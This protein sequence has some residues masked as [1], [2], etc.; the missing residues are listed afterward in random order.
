VPR[1][2]YQVHLPCW[3]AELSRLAGSPAAL[4]Q[5]PDA[6]LDRLAELGFDLLWA[7]GVWETGPRARAKA[8]ERWRSGTDGECGWAEADVVASPFAIAEYRLSKAVGSPESFKRFRDR[9]RQRGL[10]LMVDFVPNHAGL[11]SPLLAAQPD[12]FVQ[13]RG[14]KDGFF[15]IS[16]SSGPIHIAHGKDPY[17]PAWE[18]TAQFE[19][20]NPDVW[21]LHRES[22]A[23]IARMADA[24]R[25]DMAMLCLRDVF[26][27]TWAARPHPGG[28]HAPD[29]P[30]QSIFEPEDELLGTRPAAVAEAYWDMEPRVLGA[31]LDFCYLKRVYD[32]LIQR[33]HSGL[34]QYLR[35]NEQMLPRGV[36]FLENHDEARI[37]S[38]LTPEEHRLAALLIHTLPGA[39]L[40]HWGQIEGRRKFTPCVFTRRPE[41]EVQ[42]EIASYYG[43]LL[44]FVKGLDG[45]CGNAQFHLPEARCLDGVAGPPSHPHALFLWNPE[46]GV[47]GV[48]V[49]LVLIHFGLEETEVVVE[50]PPTL[51]ASGRRRMESVFSANPG[52]RIDVSA[53]PGGRIRARLGRMSGEVFRI[54]VEA[55]PP[56]VSDVGVLLKQ[57]AP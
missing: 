36:F 50:L 28:P 32:F 6:E 37:A 5:V 15:Q 51:Q 13:S 24:V 22:L 41:E 48:S 55:G 7:M 40:T 12:C 54:L 38:L 30:L 56:K 45:E 43:A 16:G 14:P 46:S 25:V 10:G 17:F 27:R 8:L 11:D 52:S 34:A 33:N 2:I 3:L 47:H 1:R 23:R 20:R 21:R 42:P 49:W 35:Q 4:D 19:L 18:D 53:G 31:G 26:S 9:L 29:N 57:E 39:T 44:R